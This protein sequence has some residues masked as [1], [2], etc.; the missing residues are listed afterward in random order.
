VL[1]TEAALPDGDGLALAGRLVHALGTPPVLVLLTAHAD[2]ADRA[3]VAGFDHCFDKPANLTEL[4][5][6]V[7]RA[8]PARSGGAVCTSW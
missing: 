7:G 1:I 8:R 2:L 3:R 6:V 4:V 5:R